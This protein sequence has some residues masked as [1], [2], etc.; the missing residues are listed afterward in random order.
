VLLDLLLEV[1][2]QLPQEAQIGL[3][4]EALEAAEV[5]G[6]KAVQE[7]ILGVMQEQA[8]IQELLA[9]GVGDV[10]HQEI[11]P[12]FQAACLCHRV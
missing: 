11:R 6:K 12:G 7:L 8:E 5:I 10:A 3:R 9:R 4:V 1:G 2:L